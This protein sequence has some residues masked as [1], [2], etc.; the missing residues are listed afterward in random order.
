MQNQKKQKNMRKTNKT[1]KKHPE[2]TYFQ[3]MLTSVC[4]KPM[5]NPKKKQNNK[6]TNLTR[7]S[8]TN[9]QQQ[10]NTKK[11]KIKKQKDI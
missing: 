4:P 10:R 2:P 6:L 8:N 7:K 5:Q 1:R 3:Q 9:Q 11:N